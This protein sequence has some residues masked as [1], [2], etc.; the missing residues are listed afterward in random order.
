MRRE[1]DAAQFAISESLT[2]KIAKK[3]RKGRKMVFFAAF[4]VFLGVL[5]G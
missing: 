1:V 2:A 4:A 5:C 3:Y